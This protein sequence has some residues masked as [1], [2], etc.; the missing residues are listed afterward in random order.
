MEN[1]VSRYDST[2]SVK[3][4]RADRGPP[5]G[6][7][8]IQHGSHEDPELSSSCFQGRPAFREKP[9]GGREK[10]TPKKIIIHVL[11]HEIRHWA[12]I[13]TVL[14]LPRLPTAPDI[15]LLCG[16]KSRPL[17]SAHKHHPSTADPYRW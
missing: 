12:Q 13:A 5:G 16:R 14:R 15:R 4:V 3:T 11:A 7:L 2:V 8:G 17:R 1:E 6:S 10:A 9:Q